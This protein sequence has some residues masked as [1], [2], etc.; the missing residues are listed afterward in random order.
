MISTENFGIV[1]LQFWEV[2]LMILYVMLIAVFFSVQKNKRIRLQPEYRYYLW[3]FY[4]KLVGGM[5]FTLIYYFYYGGGDT[6]AYF[7]SSVPLANLA[8][9]DPIKYMHALFATNSW[10]NRNVF[11]SNETGFPYG[12]I[13]I[14]TMGYFMAK[15][16]SPL[17]ILSFGSY[18]VTTAL[19]IGI[20]YPGIWKLFQTLARYYPSIKPRLAF[21]VL[22][23]PSC[24]FW[25]SGILKDTFTFAAA[26]WFVHC[27]D[28]LFIIKVK[29][30]SSLFG[31]I[32]TSAILVFLKPY[33][34]M[35]LFPACVLWAAFA[36]VRLI[37][38]SIVRIF[39]LP[40][41]FLILFAG[42]FIAMNMMSDSLGQFALDKALNTIVIKQDDLKRAQYGSNYFDL[43]TIE[44]TWSSVLSKFPEATFAGMFRPVIL[45]SRN[46]MM[47][48]AGLENTL[49][50]G[51]FLYILYRSRIVHFITLVRVNPLLQMC[52]IFSVGYAFMIGVTTPNFGALV[53]FKIP[54]VP[55]FMSALFI[56]A[57]ILDVRH[58]VQKRG[59]RFRFE[60]YT[61][62]EP[63]NAVLHSRG[64][65]NG[66]VVQP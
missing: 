12:F 16:I 46:P 48:I 53:R 24:L 15:L 22:F 61:N 52:F 18:L 42:M 32:L 50:L 8:K 28:N 47:L 55:L 10:E 29:R 7:Y 39:V 1:S 66:R 26:A 56:T 30:S 14:D 57:H 36:R 54:M 38:N 23:F 17:V 21:S 11:F 63:R 45:E 34:F 44:P 60:D 13:Y 5:I 33:I 59:G 4:A 27:I 43:G 6:T 65:R 40:S 19:V 51:M 25:G 49:M 62:G 64:R 9:Q 35:T 41:L 2:P 20:T 58:A 37:K 3:G 31:L